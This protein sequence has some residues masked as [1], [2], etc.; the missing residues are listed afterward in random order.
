MRVVRYDWV[1]LEAI[2]GVVIPERGEAG[3][4]FAGGFAGALYLH[5]IGDQAIGCSNRSCRINILC[6]LYFYGFCFANDS[7]TQPGRE[8]QSIYT[9][10]SLQV[11][12]NTIV[13]ATQSLHT[14]RIQCTVQL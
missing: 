2:E 10:F 4:G 12:L 9:Q 14:P 8:D 13:Q 3:G 6:S 5:L 7:N 11:R 1:G